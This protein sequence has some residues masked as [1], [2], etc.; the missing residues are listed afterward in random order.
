MQRESQ[1]EDTERQDR[2]ERGRR[3]ITAVPPDPMGPVRG[4]SS[5]G[6]PQVSMT[7]SPPAPPA[8][9]DTLVLLTL[10]CAVALGT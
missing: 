7:G 8:P 4:C 5:L 6:G 9:L 10:P 2:E 1:E 3:L